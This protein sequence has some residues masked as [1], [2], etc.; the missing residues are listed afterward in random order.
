MPLTTLCRSSFRSLALH[1]CRAL[2]VGRSA[3]LENLGKWKIL[4]RSDCGSKIGGKAPAVLLHGENFLC[5]ARGTSLFPRS[6]LCARNLPRQLHSKRGS[7]FLCAFFSLA[8]FVIV[9]VI[10]SFQQQAANNDKVVLVGAHS[11]LLV[12]RTPAGAV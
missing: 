11:R 1:S 10:A 2:V 8:L 9:L 6:E 12:I 3:V 7:L 5:R 4:L